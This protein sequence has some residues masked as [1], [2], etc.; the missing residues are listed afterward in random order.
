MERDSRVRACPVCDSLGDSELMIDEARTLEIFGY[1]SGELGR[2]S[3]S[4]IVVICE[5]CGEPRTCRN[6]SYRDLCMSCVQIG[7]TRSPESRKKQSESQLGENNACWGRH[8]TES[9]KQILHDANTGANHPN[10]G[11]HLSD[12]T[13]SKISASERGKAVSVETKNKQ[14]EVHKGLPQSEETRRRRS[15]TQQGIT[16]D[17]WEGFAVDSLY[18]PMFNERCKESNREKY[19]RRCFIT[20]VHES[21]NT[22]KKGM[23]NKLSVHHVDMNKQQGC[24]NHTWKLVPLLMGVHGRMHNEVWAARIEY[25]LEHVWYPGGVWTP[26]VLC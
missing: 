6:D 23:V 8:L 15:A 18:C 2:W 1:T 24:D 7:K 12:G 20:G 10:F 5:K 13:R 11:K 9:Q 3:K 19:G 21:D 17:E 26:D 22:N 16:Y 4:P 14:S 25:L